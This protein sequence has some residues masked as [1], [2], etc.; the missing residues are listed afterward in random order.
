MAVFPSECQVTLLK[1]LLGAAKNPI[2]HPSPRW[3]SWNRI[4]QPP[5]ILASFS[6]H[7][8]AFLHCF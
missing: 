8:E 2:P 6:V 4:L 5:V 3:S 1:S 7:L